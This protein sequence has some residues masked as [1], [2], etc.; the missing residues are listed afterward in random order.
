MTLRVK[1]KRLIVSNTTKPYGKEIVIRK[2]SKKNS[3]NAT[4]L[5]DVFMESPPGI[6]YK[7]ETGM[8]A[9]TLELLANR[10]SIIVEPTKITASSKAF[11]HKA[12]YVGSPTKYHTEIIKVKDIKKR[13]SEYDE[14][15]SIEN[16]KICVVAD[17]LDKVIN[18][19][20][21]KVFEK[22][23]LLIDEIDSFQLDSVFRH[24]MEK[25]LDIYKEF[26]RNNRGMLSATRLD[27]SDPD[28]KDEKVTFIRYD[29]PSVRNIDVI[30]THS[31]AL[32][33]VAYEKITNT[34]NNFPKDKIL[35]A[36]NSVNG[37]FNLG[38]T[39]ASNKIIDP[40]DVS[41][42][43]S[44]T[45]EDRLPDFYHELKADILPTRLNFITSAYFTGFD[46]NE[47][48]H[49]ISISGNR[50]NIQT[51]SD[52]RLKQIAGRSRKGLISETII[53]D[54]A[55]QSELK[56]HTTQE[57]IEAAGEELRSLECLNRHYK[58]SKILEVI[59]KDVNDKFLKVLDAN[60]AQFIYRDRT[61]KFKISYLNIDA[62]LELFRVRENLYTNP[63]SLLNKLQEDGHIV[64]IVK[65]HSTIKVS[66][67]NVSQNT[68]NQE[69]RDIIEKLKGVK[70]KLE[71]LVLQKSTISG[72]LS[73]FQKAIVEDF[74]RL[75]GFLEQIDVLN[76]MEEC[77][78]D[79]RDSRKYNSFIFSAY[80]QTLPKGHIIIDR[81]KYYFG[82]GKKYTPADIL[83]RVN[84]FLAE[85]GN[86]HK[87]E[88]ERRATK[89]LNSLRSTYRK[90]DKT[91]GFIYY[92]IRNWNPFSI[93]VLK[94]RKP[95]TDDDYIIKLFT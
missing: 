90:K 83:V 91:T 24:N 47:R 33:G 56:S 2:F 65:L 54:V 68:R 7:D 5:S 92:H 17:S 59:L 23:F 48:F 1:N 13:I 78:I 25:C 8:G 38:K 63:K 43:C 49:L 22:Y 14:D 20:G 72:K 27:F 74:S 46:L 30:T 40:Q 9:T 16:K 31:S 66:N 95:L 37:C 60:H 4:M 79:K 10:N 77:L 80:I 50:S 69:I 62:K 64:N 67:A 93:K 6:I 88:T 11:N 84:L 41:L 82:I 87:V 28:L 26:P 15:P 42:L 86:N 12:L 58:K 89:I 81:L 45:N 55:I 3:M 32:P 52:R 44:I 39:I 85:T 94:K 75:Y 21:E 71:L 61:G 57:L 36:Y 73:I 18:T 70:N 19:I 35:V 53:H 51:L 29:I 34:L 76:K